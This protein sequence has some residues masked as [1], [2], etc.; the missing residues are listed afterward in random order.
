[1][2]QKEIQ[3]E[4]IWCTRIY[5]AQKYGAQEYGAKKHFTAYLDN[6]GFMVLKEKLD[7]DSLL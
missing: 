6:V 2:V 7:T 3:C 1:M 5:G 4:R